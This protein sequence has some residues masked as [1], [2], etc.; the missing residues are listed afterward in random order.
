[1]PSRSTASRRYRWAFSS[2]QSPKPPQVA[3]ATWR[4]G[5]AAAIS[6]HVSRPVR[7]PPT[8]STLPPRGEIVEALAQP[9][10]RARACHVVGVLGNPGD[11][12]VRGRA[13]EGVD[14]GVV[15][16]LVSAVLVDERDDLAVGVQGGDACQSDVHARARIHVAQRSRREVFPGRELVHPDALD[17]L[18][19]RVDNGDLDVVRVQP[20]GEAPGG[21]GSG[22]SGAE[23]DDAV[24]H[25]LTPV[26]LGRLLNRAEPRFLTEAHYDLDHPPPSRI[27]SCSDADHRRVMRASLSGLTW[28]RTAATPS[29]VSSRHMTAET[30]SPTTTTSAGSPLTTSA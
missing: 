13:A 17:E 1:M 29:G 11:A 18:G 6:V 22:V 15:G 9:Q 30:R 5:R 2:S 4:S 20:P 16:D 12:V 7:P 14:E 3:I 8:T 19:G 27:S 23:D 26:S 21:A 25:D 24:L 28:L 10:R